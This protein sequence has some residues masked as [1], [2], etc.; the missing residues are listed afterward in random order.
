MNENINNNNNK[1]KPKIVIKKDAFIT[2]FAPINYNNSPD[3]DKKINFSDI[4][5]YSALLN[6]DIFVD[7][8]RI[9]DTF[10]KMGIEKI[11]IFYLI[12]QDFDKDLTKSLGDF[13]QHN[14]TQHNYDIAY[15]NRYP[16]DF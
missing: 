10:P 12:K 5:A 15:I 14:T 4:L 9:R 1:I 2:C 3:K 13:I 16:R 6:N 11:R 8:H 7:F